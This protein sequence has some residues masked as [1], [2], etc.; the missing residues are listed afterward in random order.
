LQNRKWL[1]TTAVALMSVGLLAGCG[2]GGGQA[3]QTS[4]AQ[5]TAAATLPPARSYSGPV[6]ATYQGGKLTKS[7]LDTEYNLQVVLPGLQQRESKK[8]FVTYYIVWYKYLYQEAK[9][10]KGITIDVAQANQAA[11]QSLAQLVGQQYKTQQDVNNKM[12]SLGLNKNDL[13]RLAAKGQYLQQYLQSQVKGLNVTDAQAQQY[14]NQHKSDYIQVTVDHIL[15][16]TE[17]EAKKIEAQLKAGANFKAMADKYSIDPGVKQNHGTY[18][19]QLASQFVPAF[20]KAAETLP[21]G[22]ISNPV[23]SQY[24]YHIMR[25]DKRT[26]LSFAQVKSQ[27]DQTLLPQMQNQKEQSIY[28]AAVSSAKINIVSNNL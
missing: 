12:T 7:E 18:A 15:V 8:A 20:A 5:N 1:A 28:Q 17:A 24:G 26:Q 23:H 9:K 21:I 19:N 22:K 2:N 6:V 4:S 27:I 14:Y 3:N 25:V 10:Q 11:D 13:V 16:K